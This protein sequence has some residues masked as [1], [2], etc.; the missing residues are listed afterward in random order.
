[1]LLETPT[2]D[3]P[4]RRASPWRPGQIFLLP[5]LPA[6]TNL[7]AL[8]VGPQADRRRTVMAVEI[9]YI[10]E[11]LTLAW[12][13]ACEAVAAERIYLGRV[14]L[15]PVEAS[16]AFVGRTLANG[17]PMYCAM[18]GPNLVGW[19][20]ISPVD[21][22]ECAH[23]GVLGMGVIASHR[24]LGIG[25]RLLEPCLAHAPR[26]GVERV[27]LTVYTNNQPAIA[28]YRKFGFTEFGMNRD[29]RRVDGATYDALL[30]SR[31]VP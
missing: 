16:H 8:A 28:L 19:A 12:R 18:D 9:A 3:S 7:T 20:D 21:I 6:P 26:S 1:M 11:D 2:L 10:R 14:S 25:R 5:P 13:A 22:P 4:A 24:G 15:P 31:A 17:W 29:Y 30:M 27:E 23:R